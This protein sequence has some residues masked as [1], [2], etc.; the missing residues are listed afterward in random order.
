M[1]LYVAYAYALFLRSAHL[2][3]FTSFLSGTTRHVL[4]QQ[5][6]CR[7]LIMGYNQWYFPSGHPFAMPCHHANYLRCAVAACAAFS[8]SLIGMCG[9]GAGMGGMVAPGAAASMGGAA[10][11]MGMGMS[12]RQGAGMMGGGGVGSGRP[13]INQSTGPVRVTNRRQ[14]GFHPYAR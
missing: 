12:T 11:A 4:L 1:S 5:D 2:C 14:H 6:V 10:A 8:F 7:R 9:T 13:G 3:R